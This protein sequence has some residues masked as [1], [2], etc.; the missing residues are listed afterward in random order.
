MRFDWKFSGTNGGSTFSIISNQIF[1]G[2][3]VIMYIVIAELLLTRLKFKLRVRLY[4]KF[5]GTK[6]TPLMF[7]NIKPEFWWMQQM[8]VPKTVNGISI[9]C[10]CSI[11]TDIS[12]GINSRQR[13]GTSSKEQMEHSFSVWKFHFGILNYMYLSRNPVF[14][15]NFLFG[16]TKLF[17]HNFTFSNSQIFLLNGKHFPCLKGSFQPM[18]HL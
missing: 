3:C 11:S 1:V 12:T 15:G 4:W 9:G 10:M 14:S 18:N 7:R 16:Q 2:F 6:G 17:F 8:N 5:F 13:P